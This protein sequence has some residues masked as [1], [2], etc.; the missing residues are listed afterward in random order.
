MIIVKKYYIGTN[1]TFMEC[2]YNFSI[3]L[4]ATRTT[5][6]TFL[7]PFLLFLSFPHHWQTRGFPP[8]FNLKTCQKLILVAN[9]IL[10]SYGFVVTFIFLHLF[11][12]ITVSCHLDIHTFPSGT[13]GKG[14]VCQCRRPKRLGFDPWVG[15]IPRRRAQQPISVFLPGESHG[16]RW[17]TIQRVAKSQTHVHTCTLYIHTHT[18]IHMCIY[19]Y[20]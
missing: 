1:F 8:V 9:S 16:H 7:F 10:I 3:E 13:S 2:N 18:G 14:P 19:P 11:S 12:V 20:V 4:S 6:F 5:S 17:A 15:K